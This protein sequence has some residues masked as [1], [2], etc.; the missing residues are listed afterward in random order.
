MQYRHRVYKKVL[1]APADLSKEELKRKKA[2]EVRK[3]LKQLCDTEGHDMTSNAESCAPCCVNRKPTCSAPNLL[4][5]TPV[6][7]S[8]IGEDG[9]NRESA[10][11]S[12]TPLTNVLA[13]AASKL[14]DTSSTTKVRP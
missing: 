5:C 7:C 6:R 9:E 10:G 8:K 11:A 12:S 2:N 4:E 13:G 1:N 14:A 3:W